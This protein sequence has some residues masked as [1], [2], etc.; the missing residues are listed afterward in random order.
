M[1]RA[2]VPTPETQ[3]AS[4][5]WPGKWAS[6]RLGKEMT[7]RV[8]M[9]SGITAPDNGLALSLVSVDPAFRS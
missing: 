5:R 1:E 7:C 2:N 3:R 4:A 9:R 6:A 8:L